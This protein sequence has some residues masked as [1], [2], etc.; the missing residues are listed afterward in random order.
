M[1]RAVCIIRE[2]AMYRK[3]IKLFFHCLWFMHQQV[4][5]TSGFQL[6]WFYVP[7]KV[8]S[9]WCHTCDPKRFEKVKEFKNV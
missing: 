3:R 8:E 9:V 5:V 2:T 6:L 7:I 1:A 4:V